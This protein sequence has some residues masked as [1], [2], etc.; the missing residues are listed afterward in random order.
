MNV[1]APSGSGPPERVRQLDALELESI[2]AHGGEGRIGF[3]RLFESS[4]FAARVNFVD[5]A[6]V[7]PGATIGL[8][9]HG[10]DEELY[11]VLE[12]RGVLTRDGE[13]L[14]VRAGSVVVN[15]PGGEHGLVNEGPSPL[16]LFVIE[17]P[18]AAGPEP[19]R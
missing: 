15:R 16:R 13:R 6:V 3:H 8:H 2:V 18:L 10:A 14:A 19:A 9:R 4:D 12:G 7:P 1:P 17:L 11:L 5:Y